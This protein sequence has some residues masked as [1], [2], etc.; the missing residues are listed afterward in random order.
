MRK[1]A[2]NISDVLTRNRLRSLADEGSY[3][4][5]SD[6]WERG[7]VHSILEYKGTIAAKVRGTYQY[8]VKLWVEDGGLEYECSCPYAEEGN[9]CKH[10]VA[11][12]LTWVEQNKKKDK[13]PFKTSAEKPMLS[14]VDLESFLKKQS[15]T[16]LIE[17]L[18]ALAILNENLFQSLML[19]AT[20]CHSA[21][22]R[23]STLKELLTMA[24]SSLEGSWDEEN[25]EETYEQVDQLIDEIN[26]IIDESLLDES[27]ELI[28]HALSEAKKSPF[29][30]EDPEMED[31]VGA[32]KDMR[33]RVKKKL[34]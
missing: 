12:G 13:K 6:Y 34:K 7:L 8:T 16:Y 4:R 14:A 26:N 33:K 23:V 9:F 5:G 22:S 2:M 21:K 29:Y 27:V 15:K 18:M 28:E 30:D 20:R 11:V 17:Q 31:V 10:C 19:D 25:N 24:F 32:L 3:F 1:T